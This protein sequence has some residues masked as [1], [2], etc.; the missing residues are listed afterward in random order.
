MGRIKI[1]VLILILILVLGCQ[2]NSRIS[3]TS[4]DDYNLNGRVKSVE[5]TEY[6]V[7]ID[8][9]ADG[10]EELDS[11]MVFVDEFGKDGMIWRSMVYDSH[12]DEFD[13]TEYTYS[14]DKKLMMT[15]FSNFEA[16]GCWLVYYKYTEEGLIEEVTGADSSDGQVLRMKFEYDSEGREVRRLS[17]DE[18]DELTYVVESVEFNEA[19]Q[20]VTQVYNSVDS[21]YK[22][23]T[24]LIYDDS[25][26]ATRFVN[27]DENGQV[28]N[29]YEKKYDQYNNL[30]KTITTSG[31]NQKNIERNEYT[32][33]NKSNWIKR[34]RYYDDIKKKVEMRTIDYY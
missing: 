9:E 5:L 1:C 28:L 21:G 3:D 7:I 17:F 20:A 25:G 34:V 15:T 14:K 24:E 18:N 19:G 27:F 30:I 2:N 13:K 12:G 10:D 4:W 8:I 23:T 26:N 11:S 22:S 29:A 32:Y 33:D 6:N 16:H 31:E